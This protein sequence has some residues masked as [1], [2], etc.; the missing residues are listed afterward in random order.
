MTYNNHM[1]VCKTTI[2]VYDNT[3]Y[4]SDNNHRCIIIAY[5]A[6]CAALRE[7]RYRRASLRSQPR[8]HRGQRALAWLCSSPGTFFSTVDFL[9]FPR[10]SNIFFHSRALFQC[11]PTFGEKSP[12]RNKTMGL[13]GTVP[14]PERLRAADPKGG[15]DVLLGHGHL[16]HVGIII[17]SY[18]IS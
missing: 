18:V 2:T 15:E 3:Y 4:D 1:V 9:D 5:S 7:A 11:F 13:D 12:A 6:S 10:R 14:L 16:L 8:H 17:M